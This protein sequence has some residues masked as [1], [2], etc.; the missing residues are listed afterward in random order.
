MSLE[1]CEKPEQNKGSWCEEES[2]SRYLDRRRRRRASQ[3]GSLSSW[4][5]QQH[6]YLQ[7]GVIISY[8]KFSAVINEK[9][10][11]SCNNMK[12]CANG[13]TFCSS[14]LFATCKW[15]RFCDCS[16]KTAKQPSTGLIMTSQYVSL[17]N[18]NNILLGKQII[19][20]MR[21]AAS[22]N[23]QKVRR[24]LPQASVRLHQSKRRTV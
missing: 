1:L 17:Y 4:Q 8:E 18:G 11:V 15:T 14:A 20:G 21:G 6:R 12:L 3:T 10:Y 7:N 19:D 13:A 9:I 2:G 22:R 5:Q 24:Q 16:V 23:D